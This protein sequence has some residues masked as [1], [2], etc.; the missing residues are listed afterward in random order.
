[1]L[2]QLE[3]QGTSLA[4]SQKAEGQLR[5]Q[6]HTLTDSCATLEAQVQSV[7]G[8]GAALQAR[9]AALKLQAAKV[10][11][12]FQNFWVFMLNFPV[13]ALLAMLLTT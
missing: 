7:T 6:L 4:I 1:M 12:K 2:S 3:E 8:A 10:N 9:Y 11:F 13:L 5:A